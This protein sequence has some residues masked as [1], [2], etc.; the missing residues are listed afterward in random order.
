[1]YGGE[2]YLWKWSALREVQPTSFDYG[3]RL[4]ELI[5]HTEVWIHDEHAYIGFNV[6]ET[7]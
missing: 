5:V 7:R 1:M 6:S 4:G 3:S 2:G